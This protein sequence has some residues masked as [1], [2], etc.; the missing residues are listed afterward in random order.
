VRPFCSPLLDSFNT[1]AHF[2]NKLDV[3]LLNYLVTVVLQFD[4]NE[5]TV[6]KKA[7]EGAFLLFLVT[8]YNYP[9]AIKPL[10][11]SFRLRLFCFLALTELAPDN[12]TYLLNTCRSY[13][14]PIISTLEDSNL[15]VSALDTITTR[16]ALRLNVLMVES[17]GT[18]PGSSMSLSLLQRCSI[19]IT[20]LSKDVNIF[21]YLLRK[22]FFWWNNLT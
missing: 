21:F 6:K 16:R 13:F 11:Q 15:S 1:V 12:S 7:P 9:V 14:D 18:A 22:F 8:R 5:M 4:Y 10:V 19:F 3:C 20:P 17:P 2:G